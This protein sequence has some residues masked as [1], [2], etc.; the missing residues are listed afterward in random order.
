[1]TSQLFTRSPDPYLRFGFFYPYASGGR[2]T[3]TVRSQVDLTD[4]A[5]H[6][7]LTRA[8]EEAGYDYLFL[9]DKWDDRIPGSDAHPETVTLLFALALA[10]ILTPLTERIGI[11]ST[12]HTAFFTPTVVARQGAML[13]ALSG[14]RW[15]IN[16]VSGNGQLE[17]YVARGAREADHDGR[18]RL[19]DEFAGAVKAMW[20]GAR[21]QH[22]GEYF[23]LD[24]QLPGPLPLQRPWPAIIS[25]GAS[26]AGMDL[27]AAHSDYLF[28]HGGLGEE[29][30]REIKA[31]LN[32]RLAAHGRERESLKFQT[33]LFACVRETQAAADAELERAKSLVDLGVGRNRQLAYSARG[34]TTSALAFGNPSSDEDVRDRMAG[35][36]MLRMFSTPEVIAERLVELH[37]NT[38]VRGVAVLFPGDRADEAQRFARFVFPLLQEAGVWVP[39]TE[40]GYSW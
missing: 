9:A 36:Q 35:G 27:A 17:G 31:G 3:L 23:D 33:N 29:M 8:A 10:G 14:G 4:L 12:V 7:R 25:A 37:A 38:D 30:F 18:Y 40:R 28:I 5:T 1:M 6:R 22:H 34:A 11:I 39:P 15:G 26:P 32:Q 20:S 24:G 21:I 16:V 2:G 13:D 19:A